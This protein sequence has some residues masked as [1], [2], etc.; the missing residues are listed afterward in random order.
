MLEIKPVSV[1][2][3]DEIREQIERVMRLLGY[4][5]NQVIVEAVAGALKMIQTPGHEV[6]PRIVRLAQAAIE[7][8]KKR[9]VVSEASK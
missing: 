3:P 7:H 2:I 4:S 6:V 5:R 9:P 1:K 8:E